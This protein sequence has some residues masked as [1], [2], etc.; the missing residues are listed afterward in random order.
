M[1]A[2]D[3]REGAPNKKL[4][5][6][7]VL[8]VDDDRVVRALLAISLEDLGC[9]ILTAGNGEEALQ[10]LHAEP[11]VDVVVAE[12]DMPLVDGLELL[13]R[14]KQSARHKDLPVIL[15]SVRADPETMKRAVENGCVLYLLKPIEPEFLFEQISTILRL[16]T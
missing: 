1:R 9:R 14:I 8:L 12:I 7:R 11:S 15:C 13:R 5:A 16:V 2:R 3:V 10:V 6:P 4:T